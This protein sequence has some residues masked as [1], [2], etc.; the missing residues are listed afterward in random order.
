M[1]TFFMPDTPYIAFIEYLRSE[2]RYSPHT[3][4]AYRNDLKQ[5]FEYLERTCEQM[6]VPA[7]IQPAHIKSWLAD[8]MKE[9]KDPRS[10]KRKISTLKA[11][12]KFQIRM[13]IVL[14]TPMVHVVSPKTGKKL[15]VY[16]EQKDTDTLFRHMEFPEDWDGKTEKLVLLL[17]Y[18]T[19]IRLSELINIREN[20]VDF[21]QKSIKVMGKGGKE[22]IIPV[23]V[24]LLGEIEQYNIAKR[25]LPGADRD[26]LLVRGNGKK[27]YPK[28][29]YLAV[30]KYLSLV[31]T[32]RKKSPHILRHTFA[33][34][35]TNLGAELN[36][37]KE[38]LGHSSLAATQVYTH[39]SIEQLKNIYKKAHPKA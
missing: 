6:P 34:H 36:A 19:G 14:Q 3:I 11:Y 31:T 32:V 21:G 28:Y 29:V 17:F 26:Y 9:K 13:G 39:N 35:L 18:H 5:F 4:T 22:R 24:E 30:K 2:K 10:V 23:S 33:T 1:A 20:Q 37:V 8:L 12:F 7:D 16:I 15:P 27:L 38:L 25:E